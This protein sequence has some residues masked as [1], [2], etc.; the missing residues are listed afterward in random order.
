MKFHF[1][2]PKDPKCRGPNVATLQRTLWSSGLKATQSLVV[3]KISARRRIITKRRRVIV[4][5]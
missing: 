5:S 3:E 4:L 2:E 1:F